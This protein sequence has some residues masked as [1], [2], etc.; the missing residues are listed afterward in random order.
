LTEAPSPLNPK[1]HRAFE[2]QSIQVLMKKSCNLL[3][4]TQRD[5]Y[6]V[7][8]QVAVLVNDTQPDHKVLIAWASMPL[9]HEVWDY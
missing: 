3:P 2:L 6:R 8:H 4:G 5:G 9:G 7:I 1:N